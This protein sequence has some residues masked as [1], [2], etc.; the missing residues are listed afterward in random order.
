M[1]P[2]RLLSDL[3]E[4]ELL[5]RASLSGSAAAQSGDYESAGVVVRPGAAPTKLHIH[6]RVP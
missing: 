1:M 5:A 2:G 6:R 4:V 3:A